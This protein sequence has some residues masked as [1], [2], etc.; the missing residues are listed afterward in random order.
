MR[1]SLAKAE[2]REIRRAMGPAVLEAMNTTDETVGTLAASVSGLANTVTVHRA[3]FTT[4]A[5]ID[6]G[7]FQLHSERLST[8][9]ARSYAIERKSIAYAGDWLWLNL[10]RGRGLWGRL[11]WLVTGR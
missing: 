1:Q 5:E 9:E 2:R 11:R 10:L 7:R 4:H 8:L 6:A 3:D